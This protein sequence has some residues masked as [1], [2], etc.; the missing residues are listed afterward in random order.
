MADK[1]RNQILSPGFTLLEIIITIFIFSI[2]L[3]I[4][5]VSFNTILSTADAVDTDASSYEMGKNC[6]DRMIVD[7]TA[8]YVA[9]PPVY[10]VPDIDDP[11][12][13]YRF[14]GDSSQAGDTTFGR[15]RF[16]SLSHLPFGKR[17]TGGVAEITY[18]VQE[19]EDQTYVLK[20]QDNLEPF[21]AFEEKQTDP[22]LCRNVRSLSFAYVDAEREESENWDSE[23]E[24]Y[25]RAT[26]VAV[27]IRLSF[28][29]DKRPMIFETTAELPVYREKIE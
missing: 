23:S 9:Q 1:T 17:V 8:V 4:L 25:D 7:L 6:L 15:L 21:P 28:G 12:D 5:F 26:P 14:V 16:A 27:K 29:D 10:K 18:Y 11:L 13:P 22:I 20:R 24:S 3:S 2:V 19:T